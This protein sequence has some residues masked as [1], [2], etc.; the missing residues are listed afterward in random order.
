MTEYY[1][2][3]ACNVTLRAIIGELERC[4]GVKQSADAIFIIERQV[5]I[6]KIVMANIHW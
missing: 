1:R 4:L 2:L 6:N 3:K 5:E